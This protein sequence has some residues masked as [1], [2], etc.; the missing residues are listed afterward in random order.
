MEAA[1]RSRAHSAA[2]FAVAHAPSLPQ[3]P[4]LN[5]VVTAR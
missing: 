2:R 3:N 5:V 1:S 4:A